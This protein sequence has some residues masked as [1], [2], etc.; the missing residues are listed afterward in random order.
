MLK[1]IKIKNFRSLKNFNMEFNQGLNVIIGE[2]DAGKTSLIDSLKILFSKKKIDMNDFNEIENPVTIELEDIDYTYFME[3]KVSEDTLINTYKIKP[4]IEKANQIKEE[5]ESNEFNSLEEDEQKQILRKYASTFNTTYRSNSKVETLKDNI[6]KELEKEE[7]TEVKTLNY[8]ISFLGSRE[9]ENIDSFF[10]N[11]FFKELK[12]DIWDYKIEGKTINQ[13]IEDYIDEFKDQQLNNEN[14]QELNTQLK[15]FLPDFKEIN[16]IVTSEPKLN[17]KINVELLNNN[18]QQML[19]EKMGDGT[20]RRTTLAIFKH[21]KDKNDLVYV[22]DEVET[23]LHIKAQLDV[24]RLLKDLSKEGKQII[25]TTHS[26][27]LINQVKLDEIKLISLDAD[28]GSQI[29]EL[30]STTQTQITLAN[31]GI[32]NIDLFFTSKLLIVEGESE[33]KFIPIMYEKLYGYPITQNFLK[34]VKADGIKDIPNFIRIIKNS[35]SK[36]DI[37]ALMDND[38]DEETKERLNKWIENGM[39]E[40]SNIFVIGQKEFEDTFPN[41]VLAQALSKYIS[42]ECGYEV[43]I[44]AKAIQKIRKSKKFSKS[45]GDIF[46]NMTYRG[47]SKPTFAQYLALY[48]EEE[49]IDEKFIRLFKLISD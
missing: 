6:I 1:S 39:I 33:L 34:I 45:L 48:A 18:N 43:E 19:L 38:A 42:D 35:F 2:N 32:M 22:F 10:E 9:F 46:Y 17:L 20:N 11:T 47:F 12:E 4:S 16:P 15:E 3:S 27:F 36:T 37:F 13:H 14:A 49:D 44:D 25:I 30:D 41:D 5:L 21:K 26:P 40:N 28:R 29:F 8:P 23:H 7:F 31:L 24:L